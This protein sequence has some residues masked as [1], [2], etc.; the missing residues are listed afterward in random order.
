MGLRARPYWPIAL[1]LLRPCLI[2][3]AENRAVMGNSFF[4]FPEFRM[5]RYPVIIYRRNSHRISGL[6]RPLKGSVPAYSPKAS[7]KPAA[8]K[9]F[10]GKLLIVLALPR[11]LE[12]LFSP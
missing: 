10:H 5:Q 3:Q 11:G 9:H 4:D 2:I 7:Q 8:G 12:P 6:L 1:G